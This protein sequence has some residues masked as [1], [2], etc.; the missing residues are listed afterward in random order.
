MYIPL[1]VTTDYSLL[2]SLIKI[3]DLIVYLQKHN[4]SSCAVVDENLFGVQEFYDLCLQN[5]IKPIIGM[6]IKYNNYMIYLY[7]KNYNGY[8]NL[9]KI[10]T[11]NQKKIIESEDLIKYKDDILVII[12]FE[13]ALIYEELKSIY[14]SI[15]LGFKDDYEYNILKNKSDNVVYINDIRVFKSNDQEYLN[16]LTMIENGSK[17][18]DFPFVQYDD[19][20]FKDNISEEYMETTIKVGD[21]LNVVIPKNNRYLPKFSDEFDSEEYLYNLCKKGLMKRLDNKVSQVY[22]DR[23][24]YELDV[25]KRMGFIDYFLIV[26]DYVLFSKKNNILVGPGRGSAA[27][28]L[29][30]Y[31]LGITGIDPI[32]YDLLFERFLNPERITMPDIDIDFDSNKRDEVIDY[33]KGKYGE[34]KCMPIMTYSTLASKM[35]LRD[36]CRIMDI[37]SDLTN[38]FV[39]LIEANE[40][41]IDNFNKPKVQKIVGNYKELFEVYKIA[42]KLEGLKRQVG[43]HAAGVVISSVEIDEVI[44]IYYSE[45]VY[46]TGFTMNYL[47]E[48]GL[49]KMDLLGLKNLSTITDTLN[50]ISKNNKEFTLNDIKYDDKEVYKLF[51]NA[52]TDGIFQFEKKGMQ[53]F[54][55]KLK[56]DCFDD[57]VVALALYRPGPMDNIELFIKRKTGQESV[58][59]LHKDLEPILKNT[60]GIIVYQ[61]QILQILATLGN[62]SLSEADLVRRAISKKK[63]EVLQNEKAKF[64]TKCSQN[65]ISETLS[66]T[67]FDFI[68]KFANYGFNKSH[69]VG[70]ATLA[71]QMA[72]LSVH[73]PLC[74]IT[75]LLNSSMGNIEKTSTYLGNAK[76]NKLVLIKPDINKSMDKYTIENNTLIIPLTVIKNI[77][78]NIVSSIIKER[79]E[80]GLYTDYLDFIKRINKYNVNRKAIQILIEADTFREFNVSKRTLIEN[81][82]LV[83][84]YASLLV[85]LD[86]SLVEKPLLEPYPEYDEITLREMELTNYGFYISNHPC[87]KVRNVVK[88]MDIDDFY[89]K[90]VSIYVL[91]EFIKIIKTKNNQEMAFIKVSDET[92]SISLTI[93]PTKMNLIDYFKKNSC[94]YVS[95]RV[96]KR[97]DKYQ[98]V[99]NDVKNEE[100]V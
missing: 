34:T 75:S 43:T 52:K 29:V 57:L 21:L 8:L 71:Y 16:Y 24:M 2:Q 3:P 17:I 31:S 63:M 51:S 68:L 30:S 18:A 38:K 19:N 61:E 91:V 92:D 99:V 53:D 50:L 47:E 36:I 97:F 7:A 89:N 44:P 39:S 67:I 93:F 32:K 23:L 64:V 4:I 77:G 94:L 100:V 83:Y 5:N 85:D 90:F 25:I 45:E 70:Y 42:S 9:L 56:P 48:L 84:N 69:S 46:L 10:N 28:S 41:L 87:L 6:F 12:N 14:E 59:Y 62:Y 74:F 86:E 72:Y 66:A 37:E 49:I 82:D 26:Y 96:E 33:I 40:S 35:I 78:N 73:Y 65:N 54:L 81:I 58:T 55:R 80:N 1:K 22:Y 79:E 76:S 27:G 13:N 11:L 15:Y 88:L 60:Y 98:I 20:Y 95:G